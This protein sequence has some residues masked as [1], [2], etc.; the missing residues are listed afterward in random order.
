MHEGDVGHEVLVRAQDLVRREHRRQLSLLE[1]GK[2]LEERLRLAGDPE[3]GGQAQGS[4]DE[5]CC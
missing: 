4:Q 2:L 5:G 1:Q 3:A